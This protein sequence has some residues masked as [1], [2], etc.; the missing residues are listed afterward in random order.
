MMKG[1]IYAVSCMTLISCNTQPI[2]GITRPKVPIC[3]IDVVDTTKA[4]CG[5][6]D[7]DPEKDF[8]IESID[9]ISTTSQGYQDAELYINQLENKI[10]SYQRRCK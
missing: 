2:K 3:L 10:R 8:V 7:N 1:L 6:G 9:A 5:Y 4:I